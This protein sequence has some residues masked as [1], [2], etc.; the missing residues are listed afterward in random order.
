MN[1][2]ILFF[3]IET[4]ARPEAVARLPEPTAPANYKDADK[5]AA[6]IAEKRAEQLQSAALDPDT[7]EVV[8]ISMR[9][10]P[11]GETTVFMAGRDGDERNL[12]R[13]FW[14]A[15]ADTR[16]CLC[17]WNILHYDLPVLLRRSL[18]LGERPCLLLPPLNKYRT[19]PITDLFGVLFNWE[20]G[21]SLK[22]IAKLYGLHNPLP[23]LNGSMVAEM[24]EATLEAY[25][26]NDVDLTVQ[27]YERMAGIYFEPAVPLALVQPD[28]FPF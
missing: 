18:A 28:E 21:K 1:H 14:E 26:K 17:G 25:A 2:N 12:L 7:C 24:D 27:L 9:Y 16:G 4:K 3:D 6:Y 13:Q 20:K 10:Y 8:A 11:E 22:T 15:V 23:D 5:I 19:E